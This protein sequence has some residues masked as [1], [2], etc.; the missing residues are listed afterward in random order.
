MPNSVGIYVRLSR[1]DDV[2]KHGYESM[3]ITNQRE[4]LLA[5]VKEKGW[6][7][8][9]IYTDDGYSGTTFKRPDFQR[10]IR[11]I[12]I[13]KLDTIVTKD[14]SRLGRNY[15]ETGQYTD[16]IFPQYGIRYIAVNDNYD[17]ENE[18]NDI[19][20][21]KNILNEMYAKDISKKIKSSKI[22]NAKQ[23]KLTGGKPPYGYMRSLDNKHL[24]IPDPEAAKVVQFIFR[25]F[26]SG[27][28]GRHIAEVLNLQ[29]ILSPSAYYYDKLGKGIP[30]SKNSNTWGSTG[31]LQILKNQA[32]IGN[33][34]QGKRC[35]ASFKTKKRKLM[36]PDQWIVVENTHQPL[37]CNKTWEK[38]QQLISNHAKK[39]K[40]NKSLFS[41]ILRC[42]DCGSSMGL[43]TKHQYDKVY[44]YYRCSRYANHGNSVCSAHSISLSFLTETVLNDIRNIA[45]M[46]DLFYE[47]CIKQLIE[48]YTQEINSYHSSIELKIAETKMQIEN[49]TKLSKKLFEENQN[50]NVPKNTFKNMLYEY[51]QEQ[52][53]LNSKLYSLKNEMSEQHNINTDITSWADT[54]IQYTHI[55]KLNRKIL[56]ELI[57]SIIV[58]EKSHPRDKSQDIQINYKYVGDMRKFTPQ[59]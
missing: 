35:V 16:F 21:F 9:D 48:R 14:L 41:G 30:I 1:D 23:G 31:V 57:D 50:G 55:K 22:I 5:Y 47:P 18:D 37:I 8:T 19:A 26:A 49:V 27:N 51:D 10:M 40:P 3:S 59:F 12:E 53:K 33:M 44:A 13:G 39:K 36:S 4:Q 42:A 28:S 6:V 20:P 38:V 54:I 46:I 32:Y 34:V 43:H 56:L 7:V 45:K 52:T 29:R 58:A 15:I 24:M 11:D 2:G 25:M 17:S